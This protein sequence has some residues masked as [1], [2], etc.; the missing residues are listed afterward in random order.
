MIESGSVGDRDDEDVTQ[1]LDVDAPSPSS[2]DL[3]LQSAHQSSLET[4]IEAGLDDALNEGASTRIDCV[5]PAPSP[6]VDTESP[7]DGGLTNP[8]DMSTGEKNRQKLQ[9]S[10][11]GIFTDL[12]FVYNSVEIITVM[13]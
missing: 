13:K 1:S 4:D 8:T 3:S 5:E 6:L 10:P 11:C 7:S 9:H 12:S 2:D